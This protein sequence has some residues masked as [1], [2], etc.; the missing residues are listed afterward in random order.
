MYTHALNIVIWVLNIPR[1]I[2]I[3]AHKKALINSFDRIGNNFNFH[4][5]DSYFTAET[6]DIGDNVYVGEMAWFSGKIAIGKNVMFGPRTTIAAGNHLYAIQGRSPRFIK[7]AYLDQNSEP[8]TIED[9][10][11]IGANVT[12]LGNVTIGIGSVIGAGSVIVDDIPP[13]TVSVGY[14]CQPIRRIFDDDVLFRHLEALGYKWDQARQIIK[15]RNETLIGLDLPVINN[16]SKIQNYI[17][18]NC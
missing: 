9:D 13:F 15:K 5:R 16:T 7:P 10:V 1:R 2:L 17:Y 18:E 14:P 4:P 11:W 3:F 6:I 12:I 8:V